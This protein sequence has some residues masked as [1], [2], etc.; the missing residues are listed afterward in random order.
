MEPCPTPEEA[1]HDHVVTDLGMQ[2]MYVRYRLI[3]FHSTVKGEMYGES[4]SAQ[5]LEAR[6][7]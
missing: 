4:G 3:A 2:F 1:G 7:I 5:F 6:R